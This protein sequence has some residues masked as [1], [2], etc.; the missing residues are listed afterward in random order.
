[1]T[2]IDLSRRSLLPLAV[3]FWATAS[4]STPAQPRMPWW[5]SSVFY[6][7]YPRSFQDGNSDGIGDFIGMKDRLEY[8]AELGVDAIWVAACFDSPNVDNGYD[9]RDYRKIMPDFGTMKDFDAFLARAKQLGIRVILDMVFNHTSDQHAWFVESRSSRDNRYRNFYHWHDGKNGGP[10]TNWQTQFGGSAWTLDQKTGQYYLHSF[11]AQQP[12]LNW[13]NPEVRA[14]L[15]AIL[16]FWA[17]K[18][19]DGFR[20]DAIT[21]IA[22]P[23]KLYDLTAEEIPARKTFA[24]HGDRLSFYL[25]DMYEHVFKNTELYSVGENWGVSRDEYARITDSRNKELSSGFRFDF[26][27]KDNIDAWRKGTF[28][29]SDL[30]AFNR[31]NSFDDHPGTWPVVWLEDHDYSRSVSRYGSQLPQYRDR[32]AKLLATMMLSLRGTPFIY[33]G[34][35]IGMTNFPFRSI[36]QFDDVFAHNEWRLQVESGHISPREMLVNLAA[37][38]RDNTRTPMQWNEGTNAGFSSVK[39]WMLVNPNFRTINCSTES[40]DPR[41]V[42]SFYKNMIRIRKQ[43]P[44]LIHGTYQD[45]SPDDSPIYAYIREDSTN[46][47]LIVLNFSN[48]EKTF[49]LPER[50]TVKRVIASNMDRKQIQGNAIRIQPWESIIAIV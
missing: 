44:V 31:D 3:G 32:S 12:D 22:K 27:I 37:T 39:P 17:D 26:Q 13:E 16:K 6:E 14:E 5:K 1:M 34:Q 38:T 23:E 11:E 29:L 8:L 33:Q 21:F 40:S 2:G 35:E 10:P 48:D 50:K 4:A 20:F 28:H 15:Y 43:F 25:K 41:S 7:I 9:V 45:I 24:D 36:D 30:R 49:S 18:G 47:A 42:L 46:R 19:V